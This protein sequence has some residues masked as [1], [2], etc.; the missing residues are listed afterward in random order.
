MIRRAVLAN[1]DH[2]FT[3]HDKA[4]R[5]ALTFAATGRKVSPRHPEIDRVDTTA[6]D[7]DA[8]ATAITRRGGAIGAA[9]ER[10]WLGQWLRGKRQT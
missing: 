6:G 10:S 4:D 1:G 7:A 5:L 9:P 3:A 8:L 2:R